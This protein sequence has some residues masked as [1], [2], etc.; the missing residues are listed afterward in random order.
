MFI[1][2]VLYT[3]CSITFIYYMLKHAQNPLNTFEPDQIA[4]GAYVTLLLWAYQMVLEAGQYYYF[5]SFNDFF[6]I[7]NTNDLVHLIGISGLIT[8]FLY[9]DL[10]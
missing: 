10:N 1:P 9:E 4:Y 8:Y 3:V 6:T 2:F 5:K 7:W